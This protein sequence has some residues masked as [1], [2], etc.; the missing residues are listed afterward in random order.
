MSDIPALRWGVITHLSPYPERH[1]T[2]CWLCRVYNS[3]LLLGERTKGAPPLCKMQNTSKNS[4]S[5]SQR[6]ESTCVAHIADTYILAT[7]GGFGGS[8]HHFLREPTLD[9]SIR[10]TY[11]QDVLS[12]LRSGHVP[13]LQRTHCWHLTRAPC[14]N[15]KSPCP[16]SQASL[17]HKL[18]EISSRKATQ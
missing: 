18:E 15:R 4:T 3:S 8:R 11:S 16:G 9:F 2:C 17:C 13:H 1:L 6:W 12:A 14:P 5:L 10:N 7:L